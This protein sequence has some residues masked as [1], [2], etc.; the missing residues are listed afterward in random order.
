MKD[1]KRFHPS[2]F[3]IHPCFLRL[4]NSDIGLLASEPGAIATGSKIQTNA[5]SQYH[6]RERMG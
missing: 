4:V 3:L 6:P 5:W 2:S 1:E